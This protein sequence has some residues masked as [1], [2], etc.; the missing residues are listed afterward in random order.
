M[1]WN[2]LSPE[3]RD[4]IIRV[5]IELL[6]KTGQAATDYLIREIKQTFGSPEKRVIDDIK[7][8]TDKIEKVKN[9]LK[10][11][12][13]IKRP[14]AED[15]DFFRLQNLLNIIRDWMI[16]QK[17]FYF[18]PLS[19]QDE[20][21]ILLFQTSLSYLKRDKI[22]DPGTWV[23]QRETPITNTKSWKIQDSTSSIAHHN[24]IKGS[25]N[26]T[27]HIRWI[28]VNEV[29]NYIPFLDYK[30]STSCAFS[31]N[32]LWRINNQLE[33]WPQM[34]K[35]I[36]KIGLDAV[37]T[38]DQYQPGDL[39]IPDLTTIF[40]NHIHNLENTINSLGQGLIIATTIQ[41][42]DF[43]IRKLKKK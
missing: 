6:K 12:Q 16:K 21:I 19:I 17:T 15:R 7:R 1:N 2:D 42:P 34:S 14:N 9:E 33:P 24:D 5:S 22:T 8:L 32:I 26:E 18:M 38:Y 35:T 13:T 37:S 3:A 25:F 23:G 36:F 41:H 39:L 30:N 20:D 43:N 27:L 40:T 4:F 31:L 29:A 11:H 10:W 28:K